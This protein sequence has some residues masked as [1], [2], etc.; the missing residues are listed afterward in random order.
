M[1]APYLLFAAVSAI[2]ALLF[3]PVQTRLNGFA[4]KAT[5]TRAQQFFGSYAGRSAVTT[6]AF[7]LVLVAAAS[8]MSLVA[9]KK[10]A[11]IPTVL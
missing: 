8:I 2:A 11:D 7:F 3:N 5:N 10:A 9:G 4:G 1:F 6:A